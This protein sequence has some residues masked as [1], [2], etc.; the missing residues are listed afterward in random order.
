MRGIMAA[1]APKANAHAERWVG[2]ARRECLDWM[3]RSQRHLEAVL[4]ECCAHYTM[5]GLTAAAAFDPPDLEAR[6]SDGQAPLLGRVRLGG[7]L[8]D[9]SAT[10]IA[11]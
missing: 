2:C 9:Y 8:S 5:S 4:S 3:H 1:V 7:L 6:Q 10:P 11:T